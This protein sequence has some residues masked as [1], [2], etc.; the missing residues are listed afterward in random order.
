MKKFF[1]QIVSCFCLVMVFTV[2]AAHAQTVVQGKITNPEN[3]PVVGVTVAEVDADGRTIKADR[4]DVNGNFSLRIINKKHKLTISH[5]SH[6]TVEVAI[7]DRT[8]FNITVESNARELGDVVI[9]AQRR[10]DN[11]LVSVNEK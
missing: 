2:S 11:G 6:K 9:I 4:T 1:F 8:T 5:I 3:E 10:A 7:G